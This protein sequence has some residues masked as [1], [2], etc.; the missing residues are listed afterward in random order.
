MES[1]RGQWEA[2]AEW[3]DRKQGDTG[4]LWHRSLIDPSLLKLVG[5]V[6]G[7]AVLD[8]A[9][10]NGYL[11]RRWAR[12]G[13]RVV[14]VDAS[15]AV[16]ARARAREAGEPLG[17]EY[18]VADAA[19]LDGVPDG[20]FDLV[21]S[22]MAMMD[23]PDAAG[24]MREAARVLRPE[25]RF[26]FSISHPCFDLMSRSA[27]QVEYHVDRPAV[28]RKVTQY[29]QPYEEDVPWRVDE[30]RTFPTRGFH[31]PLAWYFAQLHSSGFA[32]E[33]LD[34]P[35]PGEELVR[36]SPQGPW[37]AQIPLHLVLACRKR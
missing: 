17:V 10:G 8:L 29:R 31:R 1:V 33:E 24:A 6:A 5:R 7:L 14:G 19:R 11:A 12:E 21:A 2:M 35:A 37:I 9:C 26:V 22:N 16:I 25:G 32:V 30:H 3:Y 15:A 13:A 34:E 23:I 4:D 36:D 18:R 20:A 28:W 27:W